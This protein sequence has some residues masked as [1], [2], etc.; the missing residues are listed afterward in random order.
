MTQ[1]LERYRSGLST[2]SPG[3]VYILSK[4]TVSKITVSSDFPADKLIS[5]KNLH[6]LY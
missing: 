5:S 1:E 6:T 3:I 2:T 4:H